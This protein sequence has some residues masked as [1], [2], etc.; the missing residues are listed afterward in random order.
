M[1]AARA[2]TNPPGHKD[3]SSGRA[4]PSVARDLNRELVLNLLRSDGPLSR[5]A[6]AQR[7]RLAKPTVSAIV[8]D[9]LAARR[10]REV[11]VAAGPVG[12]GRPAV[13]VEYNAAEYT[14]VGVRIGRTFIRVALADATGAE[15][16]RSESPTP[17]NDPEAVLRRVIEMIDERLTEAGVPRAR[18]SAVGVCVPGVVDLVTGDVLRASPLGWSNFPLAKRLRARLRAPVYVHDTTQAAAVAETIEG[19]ARGVKNA[20]VL[21]AGDRL[22]AGIV[23]DG[24]LYHGTNGLAGLIGHC[25]IPGNSE[26]CACGRTGCIE[27]VAGSGAAVHTVRQELRRGRTS[28]LSSIRPR[29]AITAQNV[30]DAAAAG[31]TLAI[32]A[33]RDVGEYVAH[34]ASWLANIL[35]PEVLVLT[36]VFATLPPAL[37]DAGK[38]RLAELCAPEVAR[39]VDLRVSSLGMEAWVRGAVL[40]ALQHTQR[41]YR[42]V[43]DSGSA[44]T[45][46]SSQD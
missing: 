28:T 13:L 2:K 33:L 7:T 30:A 1:T 42:L 19:A 6:I 10:V 46:P 9:L 24:R 35:N 16:G 27:A 15:M 43:F 40:L 14:V 36:G 8:A 31:D 18:L 41:Y 5:A 23:I 25:A 38:K 3:R 22:A 37:V 12:R 17:P 39:S 26:Q 34:A 45:A 44:P 4:L 32:E 11:G 21:D 20:V 29:S